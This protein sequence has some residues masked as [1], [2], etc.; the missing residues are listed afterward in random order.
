MSGEAGGEL[1]LSEL[2]IPDLHR[3]G[4]AAAAQDVFQQ[5]RLAMTKTVILSIP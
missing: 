4:L 3:E 1:A 5:T 2:G